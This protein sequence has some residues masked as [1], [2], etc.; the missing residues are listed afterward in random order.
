MLI[1]NNN[2]IQ[3][4]YEDDFFVVFNKPPGLLVIPTPKG[5]ART[6]VNL[7]NAQ[8]ISKNSAYKLHPCHRLDRETSGVII[9]AKGKHHQQIMMDIFKNRKITKK[10]IAFVQG[11]PFHDAGEIKSFTKS[12][13][14]KKYNKNAPGQYSITRY[15]VLE[16][17]KLFSV[18]E[19]E[20]LT[21]HTNQIRIHFKQKG[22]PLVGERKYAFGKD[23]DLKFRR[24]A[25]H[26]KSIEWLH[27]FTKKHIKIESPLSKDMEVFLERNCD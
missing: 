14:F 24:V 17:R 4:L 15:K 25:L 9:F 7:V 5:E 23:F 12:L 18:V 1:E 27:P 13:E 20:P 22:H 21:G 19:A 10:Y 11:H 6:L 2:P 26:A 16:R 3:V 8:F